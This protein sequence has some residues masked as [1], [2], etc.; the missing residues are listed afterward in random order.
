MSCRRAAK[1]YRRAG[2]SVGETIVA[3]TGVRWSQLLR[4]P[5]FD[6]SRFVV[7]D[8]M[9][10]L[11]LGLLHE[12]FNKILGLPLPK[13]GKEAKPV[14]HLPL[15]EAWKNLG[16]NEQKS[17]RRLIRWLELPMCKALATEDGRQM[18]QKRLQQQHKAVLGLLCH[19]LQVSSIP[20]HPAKTGNPTCA[21]Y[22]RGL[23]HWVCINVNRL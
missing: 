4:L 18:W 10:N 16:P 3:E 13:D 5:Y 22:A 12:H 2:P 21:D 6:P 11:F 20:T 19:E 17:M 8:P 14:L 23:V 9:H 1:Q 7:V 15:S